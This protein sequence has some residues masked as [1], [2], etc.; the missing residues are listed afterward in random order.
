MLLL[1]LYHPKFAWPSSLWNALLFEKVLRPYLSETSSPRRVLG[2]GSSVVRK[3]ANVG[4][5]TLNDWIQCMAA[6]GEWGTLLPLAHTCLLKIASDG[7]S[8]KKAACLQETPWRMHGYVHRI[9]KWEDL[10]W[11][12]LAEQEMEPHFFYETLNLCAR[13]ENAK[14]YFSI[15]GVS[16]STWSSCKSC[17][18]AKI[19]A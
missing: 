4:I 8:E 6:W 3:C 12:G 18:H 14:L 2:T 16:G 9:S 17:K 13:I 10:R 15:G 1:S 5:H 19:M 7:S 11:V